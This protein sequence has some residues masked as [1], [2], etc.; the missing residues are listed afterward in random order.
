MNREL[1]QV[2]K[3]SYEITEL[4]NAFS[5]Y[6]KTK[7]FEKNDFTEK[8]DALAIID[9]AEACTMFKRDNPGNFKASGICY[10]NIGSLQYKNGN[11]TQAADNFYLAIQEAQKSLKEIYE[12]TGLKN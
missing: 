10:N 11:Y 2:E 4:Y 9:L 3:A 1:T 12:D 7:K 5:A 8:Q 6:I